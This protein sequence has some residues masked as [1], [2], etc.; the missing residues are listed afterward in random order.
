MV[1][2]AETGAPFLAALVVNKLG[3]GDAA[4]GF[5]QQA[6]AVGRAAAPGEDERSYH[7]ASSP[8]WL[9]CSPPKADILQKSGC[10]IS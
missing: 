3:D 8:E 1:E 5:H 10:I 9:P 2:D 6:R 7:S 4:K